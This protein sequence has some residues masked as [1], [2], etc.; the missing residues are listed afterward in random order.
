M[1]SLR[2]SIT[3]VLIVILGLHA[4][5]FASSGSVQ[6]PDA[7]KQ[8][9][10]DDT[11]LLVYTPSI[12]KL[13]DAVGKTA[14][15]IDPQMA[16]LTQMVPMM[17]MSMFQRT[18]NKPAAMDMNE[19]AMLAISPGDKGPDGDPAMTVMVGFKGGAD[20]VK[21]SGDDQMRVEPVAGSNMAMITNAA[22]NTKRGGATTIFNNIPHGEI[23]IAFDQEKFVKIYGPMVMEMMTDMAAMENQPGKPADPQMQIMQAQ[24]KQSMNQIKAFMD[25]FKSMDMAMTFDNGTVNTTVRWIPTDDSEKA[26]GSADLA[27]HADVMVDGSFVSMVMSKSAVECMISM[28]QSYTD[29]TATTGFQKAMDAIYV[30]ARNS[31]REM[32]GS[33]GFSYGL[34]DKGIWALQLMKVQ[35]T[36]AYLADISEAMKKLDDSDIGFSVSNLQLLDGKGAGYTVRLDMDKMM[37]SLGYGAMLQENDMKQLAAIVNAAMGGDVG[38]QI[39]YFHDGNRIAMV[40]GRNGKMIGRAKQLLRGEG[41]GAPNTL[42]SLATTAEG[43]PTMVMALDIR[44]MTGDLLSFLHTVP[45]IS[46]EMADMPLSLPEGDPIEMT[47][48]CTSRTQG[49]QCVITFDIGPFSHMMEA[50]EEAEK[51]KQTKQAA[52]AN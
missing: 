20:G 44:S 13:L 41:N 42:T 51:A 45:A 15:S 11:V 23:S 5:A 17:T 35:S 22:S 7:M 32:E 34:N 26:S 14:A 18:G 52:M 50:L 29:S 3:A 30:I 40:A 37:N 38:M 48:T 19:A 8:H 43:S 12:Q 33:T 27:K 24:M 31:V 9:V 36:Q 28:Q 21:M 2:S 1:R 4:S 25:M 46:S 6:I 10:P 47:A 49:G 16:M 39:R